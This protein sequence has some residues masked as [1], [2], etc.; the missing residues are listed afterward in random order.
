M[1]IPF[2]NFA[3]YYEAMTM[4]MSTTDYNETYPAYE[5]FL[6]ENH[7][8]DLVI[9]KHLLTTENAQQGLDG[10]IEACL[11]GYRYA[12][13]WMLEEMVLPFLEKGAKPKIHR[14]FNA[15]YDN[16][17]DEIPEYKVRGKLIDAITGTQYQRSYYTQ[18]VLIPFSCANFIDVSMYANWKSIKAAEW[19]GTNHDFESTR[20]AMLKYCSAYLQHV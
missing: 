5:K 2:T 6:D 18:T 20:L 19:Q 10:F 7:D 13:E 16:L 8:G 17:D 1:A 11:N 15:V 12:Y 3:E 4:A 9:I 14:L